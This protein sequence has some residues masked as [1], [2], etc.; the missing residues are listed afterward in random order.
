M[1]TVLAWCELDDPGHGYIHMLGV[2]PEHRG[3]SLGR[4]L[5]LTAIARSAREGYHV[6]RL[7]TDDHRVEA[8]RLYHDLNY[9]PLV[10]HE[11]HWER[12]EALA[13][14]LDCEDLLAHAHTAELQRLSI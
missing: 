6:H 7:F 3:K 10:V 9:V 12:W 13:R 8:I 5:A 1:G 4:A 14:Q 11:S 2:L